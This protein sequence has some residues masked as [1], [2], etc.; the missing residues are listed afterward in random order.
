MRQSREINE[1][2][3][4]FQHPGSE[5]SDGRTGSIKRMNGNGYKL[6]GFVVWRG[7]KWYAARKLPSGRVIAA[8][9][10]GTVSALGAATV[11]ARR[12]SA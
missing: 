7:G 6:L 9:A 12:A 3:R 4:G 10:L 11:I 5:Y 8:A 2:H 1:A